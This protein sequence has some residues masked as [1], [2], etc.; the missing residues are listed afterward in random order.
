MASF[1]SSGHKPAY[2][3]ADCYADCY[4]DRYAGWY[5]D[6]YTDCH[7]DFSF[8][9]SFTHSITGRKSSAILILHFGVEPNLLLL[10]NFLSRIE[11]LACSIVFFLSLSLSLR[12]SFS[13]TPF[14]SFMRK[15]TIPHW[16]K[17]YSLLP[18]ER[19]SRSFDLLLL[20][21]SFP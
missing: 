9:S 14:F 2:C 17:K 13:P 8:V 3:Y 6:F 21:L 4:T 15:E 18:I 20:L 16:R 19:P 7:T 10:I 11:I 12:G 1:P 5:T